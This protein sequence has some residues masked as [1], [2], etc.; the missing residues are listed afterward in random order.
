MMAAKC[1]DMLGR[2]LAPATLGFI[3]LFFGIGQAAGPSIAGMLA[4]ASGSFTPAFIAAS[5]AA[6]SGAVG[7]AFLIKKDC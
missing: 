1:G 3:T 2:S 6:L 5:A 4:D 7:S